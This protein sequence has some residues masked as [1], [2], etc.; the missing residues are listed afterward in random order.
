VIKSSI[1]NVRTTP[2]VKK[3]VDKILKQLGITQT[4]AVNIFLNQII[5]Y[6]GLPFPVKIPNSKEINNSNE[7]GEF[8]NFLDSINGK[9]T[10]PEDW[11]LEHDHYIHGTPKKHGKK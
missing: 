6:N 11:A 7:P 9:I 10:A 3:K 2:E 8:V 1:I 4:E 5:L